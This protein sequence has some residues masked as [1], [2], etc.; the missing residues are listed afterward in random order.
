[1]TDLSQL[2]TEQLLAAYNQQ[3]QQPTQQ[4]GPDL[5]SM[6]TEQLLAAF[7]QAQQPQQAPQ[8]SQSQLTPEQLVASGQQT[9]AGDQPMT[10]SNV[11]KQALR[12]APAS[13]KQFGYDL[14]QPIL[15]PI[16]T[17][18]NIGTAGQGLAQKL[19]VSIGPDDPEATRAADAIGEHFSGRYG[20]M[21][22]FKKAVASDPVG[23]LG[24]ASMVLSGGETAL[25]RLPGTAG[26]IA[27]KTAGVAAR[28]IDP[29]TYAVRAPVA[30]A[31]KAGET[32]AGML[33]G[34]GPEAVRTAR[35]AAKESVEGS[36]AV[37]DQMRGRVEPS[38]IVTDA[39]HAA[40]QMRQAAQTSYRSDMRALA[41]DRTVLNWGDI[42]RAIRDMNSVGT[43][44]GQVLDR[45][46]QAL[47]NEI[48]TEIARW[49][50]LDPAQFH[51]P[52]GF[53]ALKKS[54][55][56]LGSNIPF[57][58]KPAR[59][60]V[61]EAADAVKNTIV[62]QAPVYADTMRNYHTYAD[63][64][65]EIQ[66]TLGVASRA[67]T[68]SALRRLTSIMR[69]NVNTNF[70]QRGRLADELQA[71]GA[72]QLRNKIAGASLN[73]WTPRGLAGVPAGGGLLGIL[74]TAIP[75]GG[76]S[77]AALPALAATSPRLVGET[78][79]GLGA[80]QR[81]FARAGPVIS[82]ARSLA[83]TDNQ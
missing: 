63:R 1:M 2:S 78:A 43:F 28:A 27:S 38:D 40:D 56:D 51:T 18:K 7:N 59:L 81:R 24:D 6:S 33:T 34:V 60:V 49:R 69:N 26:R 39:N 65:R 61:K 76:A 44:K 23:V 57:D 48:T 47:R 45:S 20:S 66:T 10:W 35:V 36:Q 83:S 73:S 68:D 14:I 58:N 9:L 31:M 37:R 22:G 16:E 50:K 82:T 74:A 4:A 64:L 80:L 15:H 32:T 3:T 71:A 54:I 46:T 75:S 55:N 12:N 19:G 25:A 52:E 79:R 53:D 13:A 41:N 17:V 8:Q 5:S 67:T 29:L 30:A 72:P 11:G 70:G 42:N 77:L 62:K 21:E